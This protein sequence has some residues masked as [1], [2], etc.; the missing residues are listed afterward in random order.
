MKKAKPI[1]I[2]TFNPP[3]DEG[4]KS[5]ALSAKLIFSPT[6]Q[7]QDVDFRT[8][9]KR[10]ENYDWILFTSKNAIIRYVPYMSEFKGKIGVLGKATERYLLEKGIVADFVGDGSSS[11]LMAEQLKEHI[12]ENER[13]LA[14][15]GE[16]ASY[17]LQSGLSSTHTIDRLEV[18][19][20]TACSLNDKDIR[21][22]II[23]G[24]YD[25]ILVASPSAVKNLL[26]NFIGQNINWKLACIGDTT[27]EAC[28]SMRVEPLL[29]AKEQSFKNLI[30]EAIEYTK[31]NN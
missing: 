22:Q 31:L 17:N 20:T 19:R 12:G 13:I 18:Y 27:A 9:N 14:V 8:S 28:R 2:C 24:N 25:L 6:I 10:A 29:V 1:L 21:R 26:A 5:L 16:A 4:V 3:T 30:E 7:I 11:K 23:E 15:L